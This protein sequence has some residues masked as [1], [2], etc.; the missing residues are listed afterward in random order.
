MTAPAPLLIQRLRRQGKSIRQI[1]QITGLA[2][3]TVCGHLKHLGLSKPV[4][5]VPHGTRCGYQYHGCRCDPCRGAEAAHR[6]RMRQ[7]QRVRVG[8][9]G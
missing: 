6:K 3:S 7:Q 9:A 1:G 8:A 2:H 4:A 5:P